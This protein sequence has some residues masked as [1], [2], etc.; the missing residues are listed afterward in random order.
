[1]SWGPLV[2]QIPPP[3]LPTFDPGWK[4]KCLGCLHVDVDTHDSGVMA[5]RCRKTKLIGGRKKVTRD[6]SNHA[7]CIDTFDNEC[8]QKGWHEPK[9]A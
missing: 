6:V 1:M 4:R 5:L 2:W 7:Y 9:A 3:S 8:R